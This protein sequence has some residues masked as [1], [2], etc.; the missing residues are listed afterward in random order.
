MVIVNVLL[1]L[2]IVVGV[3]FMDV[4]DFIEYIIYCCNS[5]WCRMLDVCGEFYRLYNVLSLLF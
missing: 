5:L 1:W 4:G 2:V 3:S